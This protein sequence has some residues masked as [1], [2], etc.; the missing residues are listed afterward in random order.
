MRWSIAATGRGIWCLVCRSPTARCCPGWPV[1]VARLARAP[2]HDFNSPAQNERGALTLAGGQALRPLW[3]PLWRMR[4]L[5]RLGRRAASGPT[6]SVGGLADRGKQ[7]RHLGAGGIAFDGSHL[8]AA[9]GHTPD[10][11]QW[12]GADAV[13]RLTPDLRLRPAPQDF[14]APADWRALDPSYAVLGLQQSVA[15]DLP[16]GGPGLP[17]VALNKDGTAYLLDRA[18]LG[19]IGHPLLVQEVAI[20]G[21]HGAR[22]SGAWATT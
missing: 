15:F 5:S 4:R 11:E 17:A 19:G 22:L 10:A 3:R 8:F 20:P 21:L 7:G 18:N 12:G 13:I 14:F 9:T 16:D 1:D 6:R 2:R